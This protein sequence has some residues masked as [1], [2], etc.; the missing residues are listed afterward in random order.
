MGLKLGGA[1]VMP[2]MV[3]AR[4]EPPT[5][6]GPAGDPISTIVR[7]TSMAVKAPGVR[8][9]QLTKLPRQF[10][11]PQQSAPGLGPPTHVPPVQVPEPQFFTSHR[12]P[13]FEA[14]LG[15]CPLHSTLFGPGHVPP[16][17]SAPDAQAKPAF[18]PP[19]Q[20]EQLAP[21]VSVQV[22][23]GQSAAIKQGLPELMPPTHRPFA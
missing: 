19:L 3:A 15:Q 10:A 14:V 2:T 11:P 18:E 17:Q 9:A 20:R 5:A 1:Q 6:R 7:A 12:A 21:W 8:C 22:E 13:G 4:G 23:L 16:G